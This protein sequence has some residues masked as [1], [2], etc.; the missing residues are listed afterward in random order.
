MSERLG[1]LLLHGGLLTE[2]QLEKVL[3]AQSVNGGRLG[4]NLVEMGLLS[5]EELARSLNLK[6]GVPVAEAKSLETV[7]GSVLDLLPQEMVRRFQVVPLALEGKRLVLAMA[8]PA[9]YNAI[10]EIGFF[11]GRVV[12]PRVCSELR[13]S[14]AMER[15]YGIK[16]QLHASE[17]AGGGRSRRRPSASPGRGPGAGADG[18]G[19]T[20]NAAGSW[21]LGMEAVAAKFAASQSESEV[22]A[23]LMSYL[24]EEFDCA[25][26]LSL[27]R[28]SAV[29]VRAV[30]AGKEIP[31][32]GG[33]LIWL[34][35][36]ALLKSVLEERAPYLGKLPEGAVEGEILAR[37][38]GT[39]GA[40]A[41]L[42]PLVRGGVPVAFLVVTDAKGRLGP[43]LFDLRLVAAKAELAFEML[44]IRKKISLV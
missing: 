13:L 6:L 35:D 5:E 26:F 20:G 33:H 11:T 21:R 1:E 19:A 18:N 41:L 27:R 2:A 10:D 25:G 42:M 14:Q 12:V 24:R 43:G 31:A 36:A 39:P 22:V 7:P 23:A 37:I 15:Y 8:D 4:T 30:A 32:F 3:R 40:P 44:G 38:G 16:R 17:V 9:D 34:D 28:G 29:E